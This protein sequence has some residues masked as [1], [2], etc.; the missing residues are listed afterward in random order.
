MANPSTPSFNHSD[1][2]LQG[3]LRASSQQCT[4]AGQG[5]PQPLSPESRGL[6]SNFST[7]RDLIDVVEESIE[8][9]KGSELKKLRIYEIA[10]KILTIIGA[11]ILFAVPL[12][13]LL[14]V[15]LWIPIV[16]CIG[17]GIAFSIAKGCLQKRCQQIREE[18]RALHLYHRYLLSNKDSI[19]GTLLS[20]FDIRFRKAE[21]KLHGLDLDKREANHP[22][23]A[24]KRYDFAGLAHQRYQVDAALGISSSQDAF[25]R[26]V[27]QQVKSVKD[28]VVLGDKAST[29]LYPIAQQALQAAGVGFSGAA[30]KESLLDLAKSLSSLFAWGS[31]VG[32]DSHEALQ[33]Y[34]M[35]FLS[36]PILATWC[37]AGFSASAQD[38]VL[39]GKNILDIASENHTKM[40]NA[41]K[42]VQLVSVLGKMR[43]WKE[44]IDTL[45]QNKNLDQDSLRKLYQ[46]IE[47]AMHKVCIEDGVSASIQTRVRKVTQKYLRQDLQE[48]LN[49][50][51][52]LNESDLSKMQEGISSCANFVVTLLESQLGISGPTPIK[53]VEE[54]IYRDLI[55]TILQMGSAAGGVTPLVDGVH[56]AIREGKTLRSELSRAMS[57]HPRQSFLGVQSAVEK[58]QAFIRDP[59]WGASAVHT[60]AE[61][62]L[63]QK[64]KFVS[65]L[66]RIQTSLADWRERYGLFEETKLNHI[67]STD[68]VSR[69]EAF[70]DTLK[71]VAEACSLEQ[72]VAELKDCEDAMKADLTHVE[73]KMNPTEIES[74]R[75]EFKRLM[76][77]LAGIQEQLEQIAQPIYEEGVSGKHLLL[78]IVFSHPEVLRK[79]VQAKEASLEA[80][81]KGEQPSPTKKKTLKQLSEGCEYFSSLVS[82]INALK[83]ILEGSRGKKIASQ[84]I[85]QL[86]GLTDELALELSSFQQDSLES[87]LYGLEGLSIPAA[88]IEQ[89]KGSP[90]SSSIAEKVVYASHQRVYNGVKAKVNRT[91]EAFSQLIKGLRGSLRNAMIT[92]AVVAAVLSVAFSCLAIALFSVQLTWLP[93]MLCVLALV[94]EA[95][96]SAL[97]IWVEKRNW[98]YEVASLAKQLVSDGRK[99]PYPDLGDQN[100]K[101]LEKIRDVYGLD[102]VAELRVAE[103]ALLGVQKL[104]EE[105]KQESLKSAVKALRADAKVL[106]KKFKKLPESYQPQ[107]SEVTG[108]QG[109]T[110]Q[111]SRDDVLVAQDMAAIEELQDQYHAACLQFESVS[112]RFL[113]EQR[114]ARFLEERLVQKRRDVSHL[115]H[116][117]AHYTQVVNRLKE[118]TSMKKGA[119]TQHASK[120]EISTKMRELLS[121]DDQLLKAHTAQDVNRDN[122][123]NGQLQQQFK[124][125]SEEG[126]LQKVKALLELNMCLGNAEQTLYHSRLKREVF[127][128]SCSRTSLQLLQYGE[129]LFASYDGSDRSALLRFVLGSGY[130]MISEASSELKSLRKRWKRS[131]SQAAIAPEDYEKVCRVLERFL[132]ARD[133]L[134]PKLGLPLGKSSDATVGLQHQIR[135][136]QR[137]KARV[138]ACYQESCRN[139]LEHLE[140]WVRKTRQESA[141][142]QKVETKIREFCQKAGSKENLAESTEMLFS[143]LEEDLNK[144]PLD[145]LRA[146]LRSL[147]SKIL[148]IMDQKLELEKLEEQFAKTNAVVKAKEAEFKKNG[149]VWHNQYQMLK[150][151]MEK[152]ESQKRRL[153]DKKE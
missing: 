22:L 47:K 32:K 116:Q 6:T 110:E 134:R 102:G 61:E 83:T 124:K 27:A 90:K 46:D 39:K 59:K 127:E 114:K 3:R 63:A 153:T 19:D 84:D 118:L 12:C 58:L 79:K 34:Q 85:R 95:I 69:T 28:D 80:L 133:S 105:Q 117:E 68:F 100:I 45:I 115:S 119:S 73:Q 30:G 72:A 148:H 16:T 81:T 71:N 11:A 146:I 88:S 48:L 10:L 23:E 143:S 107:H 64:H 7:R 5:D 67:V 74:A 96:P 91:L 55:T 36:S 129:D 33:Q 106:N 9:A 52:P 152:L 65:D 128:A 14:G 120:E 18:Y 98:K 38:F 112:M 103:S 131:A 86:I 70:L 29:D 97:S 49:K 126:S 76:E 144:I 66:T 2:S 31:Q 139:V 77:E 123:I 147:S 121:L 60:S 82:K 21:E 44:K 43:N 136:N 53:E 35:R 149:Q 87:L 113:A 26:G 142:C 132:K 51:A 17:V 104:P 50:K 101:H 89:K 78:N 56:K 13:M 140:D 108:V 41:I 145:V 137:V 42:H 15:P 122:S 92:K 135:D 8:T 20:R 111:E 40:Q 130:E 25:W 93:I 94:L 37:G 99:L 138:T 54:S 125:L 151:Q 150:S 57:L 24:D 75:E 109:V 4:Q 62:T 141:E 1:L